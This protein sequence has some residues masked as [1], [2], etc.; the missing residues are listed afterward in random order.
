MFLSVVLWKIDGSGLSLPLHCGSW[1]QRDIIA[2]SLQESGRR[3]DLAVV[4]GRSTQTSGNADVFH[5]LFG[6][7]YSQSYRNTPA[8]RKVP[9][10]G[11]TW[12]EE[13]SGFF[14]PARPGEG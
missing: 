14:I 11:G 1:K 3:L 12:T 4:W 2:R 13:H 8:V 7:L 6:S 5:F 10:S 9:G